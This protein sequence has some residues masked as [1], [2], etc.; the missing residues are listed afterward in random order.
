[1]DYTVN[2]EAEAKD[3]GGVGEIRITDKQLNG[4]K[5]EYTGAA[6]GSNGKMHSTGRLRI[7]ANVI[8]K[9]D[10]RKANTA[11]VLQ[12]YG[13]RGNATASQRE[14]AEHIAVRSQEAYRELRRM[15]G[16]R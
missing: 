11:A 7:M 10:E 3:A 4:F 1:M 16:N 9:S 8:I 2:V 6:K 5:I 12:A 15:G 13:V 14:A